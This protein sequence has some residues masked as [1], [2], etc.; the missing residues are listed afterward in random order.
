MTFKNKSML[1]SLEHALD[2]LKEAFDSE[3]NIKTQLIISVIVIAASLILKLNSIEWSIIIIMITLVLASELFNT[4][5]EKLVDMFCQG[6]YNELA[7]KSKDISAGAV[8]LVSIGA[9]II[10][11]LIFLP[12]IINLLYNI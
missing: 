9:L 1:E 5:I 2:G 4:T 12:K 6:E 8:L 10:G 7:K 11:T 3:K